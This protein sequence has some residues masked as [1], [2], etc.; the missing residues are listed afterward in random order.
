MKNTSLKIPIKTNKTFETDENLGNSAKIDTVIYSL[1]G[2]SSYTLSFF[3]FYFVKNN[4]FIIDT[5]YYSVFIVILISVILGAILSNKISLNRHHDFSQIFKKNYISLIFSLGTLSI[6]FILFDIS[7]TSRFLL[8][9]TFVLGSAI[10]TASHIY[11]SERRKKVSLI[12]KTKLSFSYFIT[13]GLILTLVNFFKILLPYNYNYFDKK[14]FAVLGLSYMS[15]LFSSIM[16]HKFNPLEQAKNKWHAATLQIKFYLLNISLI[17]ISIY[18]LQISDKYWVQFVEST[19]IYTGLSFLYFI[20]KFSE[21]I[22]N[23]TDE[24]TVSFLRAYELKNPEEHS[25]I[26]L[27]NHKYQISNEII[28]ESNLRQVLQTE[29]LKEYKNIFSFLDRRVDLRSIDA[30]KSTVL[31][32]LDSYNIRVLPQNSQEF[33]MNLHELNDFRKINEYLRLVNSKLIN[34]GVFTGCFIP[35]K[36][37]HRRFLKKYTFLVGNIFYFFDF[38]LKRVLPK[39]PLFRNFYFKLTKGKDR[40]LSLTEGLGRLVFC[41]FEIL[42]IAEI[43][44][45]VYYA[46]RKVKDPI[47]DLNHFYSSIF[48]MRR[49]GKDGKTIFVYKLRTM[50]PYAEFLQ[51]FVYL[52]NKLDGG[53]KFKED[54]RIPIWGKIFRQMWIDEL[55]MIFN[56]LKRDLKLVGVRPISRQYLSL[57]S[58]EHQKLREKFKPGLIPP[59]YADLP[60]TIEEIE[61]SEAKYLKA[62]EA[63]PLKTDIIYF[64]K[65]LNNIILKNKRSA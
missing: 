26:D 44:D 34:G 40:T 47:N 32:S 2:I 15:W 29:Y 48:K 49:V 45:S 65:A 53:G 62:Y 35:Y 38:I 23:K 46:A 28:H 8:L 43:N 3:L 4:T 30:S 50:H 14:H 63:H 64:F 7:F 33:I 24:A 1:L 20:Y 41:G 19:L 54:F 25:F 16:T 27:G 21:K 31:R 12:E 9:G 37:R 56:W 10:E 59:F 13:D 5:E 58:S 51:E 42:D 55:P 60:D 22:N 57:Y 18:V 17:A 36:N 39:L 61:E 52:K 11:R 6:L